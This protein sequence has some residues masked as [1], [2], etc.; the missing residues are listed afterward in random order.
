MDTMIHLNRVFIARRPGQAQVMP[1]RRPHVAAGTATVRYGKWTGMRRL[2]SW[3]VSGL[4]AGVVSL[5]GAACAYRGGTDVLTTRFTWFSYLNGDDIRARCV[6][7]GPSL[8]R[9]VYNA[10]Y[11]RQVR[12]YAISPT[13]REGEWILNARVL[14]GPLL[15][16]IVIDD[17]LTLA[18]D[19][20]RA[21]D[22]LAGVR[23]ST[24]LSARDVDA[25][26]GALAMSG[27]FRPALRGLRLPS[28]GFYWIGIVCTNGRVTFNAFLWPSER[29][30][31]LTFPRLLFA[32]D[33]TDE[34]IVPPHERPFANIDQQDAG[35]RNAVR[36]TLMVGDNG[37]A[38]H[39]TVF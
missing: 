32:W 1:Q 26:E 31:A 38:G 36:F 37:L 33:P 9:F 18:D 5:S 17:P 35:V 22:S 8:F 29:F 4:V 11:T 13:G 14:K 3:L 27:F 7:G 28:D 21:F 16:E 24:P 6:P 10:D 12:T 25:L 23:Q 30:D 34:P 39:H 20:L 2:I 19:P 15:R